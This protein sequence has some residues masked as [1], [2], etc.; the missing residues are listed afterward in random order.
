MAELRN[1]IQEGN[2]N[3]DIGGMGIPTI[4]ARLLI[5]FGADA[6]LR[7]SNDTEGAVIIIGSHV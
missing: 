5:L 3:M 7:F 6:V 4:Y 1:Q 2:L